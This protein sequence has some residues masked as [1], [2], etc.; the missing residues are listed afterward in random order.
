MFVRCN[1]D[2]MRYYFGGFLERSLVSARKTN[3]PQVILKL[4]AIFPAIFCFLFLLANADRSIDITDE[5]SY[6]L[7][8]THPQL[9]LFQWNW[10][11]YYTGGL[12]TLAGGTITGLRIAGIAIL[13]AV[14][15]F[16]STAVCTYCYRNLGV[17]CS[18]KTRIF[19]IS[20]STCC[21]LYFYR[22]WLLTPS[23]NWLAL[24][25]T[26]LAGSGLL[27]AA[28]NAEGASSKQKYLLVAAFIL[29]G[30]G[31]FFAFAA[32]PTTGI[33]LSIIFIIWTLFTQPIKNW[34]KAVLIS[35]ISASVPAI[36]H[37]VVL[38]GGFDAS[39]NKL[40]M[41]QQALYLLQSGH[42]F[43]SVFKNFFA[44]M[45][46][47]WPTYIQIQG[48][49][50]VVLIVFLISFHFSPLSRK[51]KP[52]M[53]VLVMMCSV[54]ELYWRGSQLTGAVTTAFFITILFTTISLQFSQ[55]QLE[56]HQSG[57][58]VNLMRILLL[59]FALSV[60]FAFGS[61]NGLFRQIVLSMPFFGMSLFILALWAHHK[62]NQRFALAGVLFLSVAL[63]TKGMHQA[64]T[65]PYR[66]VAPIYEQT[67]IIQILG[68]QDT[69]KV[70]IKTANYIRRLQKIALAAGWVEGTPLIDLTGGSPG[71]NVVLSSTFIG[72]PWTL[73]GYKGS[74]EFVHKALSLGSNETLKSAWVLT[75][76]SGTRSLPNILLQEF[77]LNFPS[78]YILVGKV[79]TG[80]RS[81]IQSLW[82][83]TYSQQPIADQ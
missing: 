21:A 82:R 47:I 1:S 7:R 77:G 80:H 76:I 60:A 43:S 19:A 67:E 62:S 46:S 14:A 66:S 55:A 58:L 35:G 42:T 79:T 37:V 44:D 74:T 57:S 63:M 4:I 3:L 32:K 61:N 49:T 38:D 36:F 78:S 12:K 17:D 5:S 48:I 29:T 83:P 6:V 24:S 30:I 13:L 52:V 68:R 75:A 33:V 73:G 81:E 9:I 40:N 2:K 20:I 41:G 15:A 69:L 54:T 8:A 25:S 34:T 71:A 16:F 51:F 50:F 31:G 23:Y 22:Y 56:R 65:K 27:L 72:T 11:G 53:L 18:K 39:F 26:L 45:S 70:D 59:F 28:T 10:Y 64:Y